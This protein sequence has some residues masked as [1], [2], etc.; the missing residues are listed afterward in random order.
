MHQD[1]IV[2]EQFMTD[3]QALAR[4]SEDHLAGGPEPR[5]AH[6]MDLGS[7]DV[8]AARFRMA[9]G[10]LDRDLDFGAPDG[11]QLLGKLHC[12]AARG[13]GLV[14]LVVLQHFPDRR[15]AGGHEREVLHQ[16][17]GDGKITGR[18]SDT[19]RTC[20]AINFLELFAGQPGGADHDRHAVTNGR[21]GMVEDDRGVRVVDD[22]IR[23]LLQR[24][25]QVIGHTNAGWGPPHHGSDVL[26]GGPPRDRAKK[27][28]LGIV[29]NCRDQ[30]APDR[31]GRA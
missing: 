13:I 28:H 31:S 20:G 2:A 16:G 27:R 1:R 23:T 21:H 22:H 12:G 8:G 18:D 30:M 4:E 3:G 11:A 15:M 6:G 10:L 14:G 5:H 9:E 17:R 24:S 26:P 7:I 25:L 19:G 29:Q